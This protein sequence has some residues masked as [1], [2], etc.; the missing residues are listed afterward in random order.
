M[1]VGASQG[2]PVPTFEDTALAGT[3]T[4]EQRRAVISAFSEDHRFERVLAKV[5]IPAEQL[6]AAL[7]D[8][9]LLEEALAVKR[10]YVGLRFVAVAFDVLL[11]IA[12]HPDQPAA[13]R[14]RAL[15]ALGGMLNVPVSLGIGK[16][17]PAPGKKRGRPVRDPKPEPAADL[18]GMLRELRA[19]PEE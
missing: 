9:S 6:H 10:G 13:Q 2:V 15:A 19:T 14:L 17:A 3:L 11:A 1:D 12:N 16:E 4:P 8:P 5:D 18:E 7:A